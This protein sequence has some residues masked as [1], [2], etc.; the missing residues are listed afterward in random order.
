MQLRLKLHTHSAKFANNSQRK[1]CKCVCGVCVCNDDINLVWLFGG[2]VWTT[3]ES[4]LRTKL[5]KLSGA[6][7]DLHTQPH[8]IIGI[9]KLSRFGDPINRFQFPSEHNH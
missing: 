3:V 6:D 8:A 5:N 1:M 9:G 7:F 4:M 2:C